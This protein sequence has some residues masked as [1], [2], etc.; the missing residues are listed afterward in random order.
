M[1]RGNEGHMLGNNAVFAD[2]DSATTGSDIASTP[3]LCPGTD[4]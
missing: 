3:D 2:L 1:I 4:R